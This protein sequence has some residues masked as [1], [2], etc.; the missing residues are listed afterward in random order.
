MDVTRAV[1]EGWK[2]WLAGGGILLAIAWRWLPRRAAVGALA[3]LTVVAALNYARWGPKTL[4]DKIDNYDLIHYYLNAKYFDEL[5]YFDLYPAVILADHEQFGPYFDEGDKYLAQDETGHHFRPIGHAVERGKWVKENRFS[6]AR[7]A[8]FTHDM[9]YLQREKKGLSDSL[10]REMIQDHG[11]N[12]TTVWTMVAR[13]IASVVPVEWVKPLGYLDVVLMAG[14]LGAIA[15]AYGGPVA[16]WTTFWLLIT[17]S[18]RWPTFT[19][20]FL[21]YDYVA[22]LLA[23]MAMLRRGRPFAAGLFAAMAAT[24]RL[25]PAMWLF[26]P[27]AKGLF[28]LPKVVHRKLLVLLGGFVVGVAVLQ[29]AATLAVGA[30]AVKVHI[31]NMKDHND[32]SNLS[33]RRIGLAL[34]LP[35]R[36]EVTP[37][38]IEKARKER[39]E[40]QKPVRY[41]I[42]GVVMLLLG[43]AMRKV[44][45]DEAW[46]YG[47]V[48]FF[49][50]T[51]ASYY[52]YVARVTLVVLHASRLDRPKHVVGLV[53]LLGLEAWTHWAETRYP[54]HRVFLIGSLAWGIAGYVALITGW[55]LLEKTGSLPKGSSTTSEPAGASA[56]AGAEVASIPQA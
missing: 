26:G 15:W 19:W 44:E 54:D 47:F 14:G 37:K 23:A 49:L 31:E 43:W 39:I 2:I 10:W 38:F 21:R 52:Y 9:V 18:T 36:G 33:S 41:A 3:A 50:L 1:T 11:F 48:P 7:W 30:D 12:G 28:S 20:A 25:F 8:A 6:E 46:A 35:W 5:G 4:L 45:D 29:G 17:Y 16:T 34:A 55:T 24:L 40:D 51:T 56:S 22:A 13:P 53:W 27:G 32:A 42:A